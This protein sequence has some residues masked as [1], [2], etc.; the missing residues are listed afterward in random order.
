MKLTHSSP[1]QSWF[2]KSHWKVLNSKSLTTLRVDIAL[3]P[4]GAGSE[5]L[6]NNRTAQWNL[7]MDEDFG[8]LFPSISDKEKV[9][10]NYDWITIL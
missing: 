1:V 6:A 9:W 2:I 5:F 10:Q 8:L 4:T 7:P 3:Y